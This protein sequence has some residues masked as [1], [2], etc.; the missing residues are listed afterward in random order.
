MSKN[1]FSFKCN[2]NKTILLEIFQNV[3]R[4]LSILESNYFMFAFVQRKRNNELR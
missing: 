3:K 2:L 4:L 1:T